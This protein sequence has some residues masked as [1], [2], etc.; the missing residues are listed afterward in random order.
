MY[1]F[2]ESDFEVNNVFI[3]FV[4]G[5]EIYIVK[6]REDRVP[7]LSECLMFA[8][9]RQNRN[10]VPPDNIEHYFRDKLRTLRTFPVCF[11]K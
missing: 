2:I 10:S 4:P 9:E 6:I 7:T 8:K 5:N 11:R 1:G 3:E